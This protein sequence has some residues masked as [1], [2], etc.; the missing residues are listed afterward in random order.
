MSVA[1]RFLSRTNPTIYLKYNFVKTDIFR[2]CEDLRNVAV[3]KETFNLYYYQAENAQDLPDW[4]ERDFKKVDTIA[5]DRRFKPGEDE[6][7]KEVREITNL[8]KKGL[9][10]AIQVEFDTF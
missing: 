1:H 6:T 10:I 2:S 7:N 8:S 9:F 4:S 5:A 3:C